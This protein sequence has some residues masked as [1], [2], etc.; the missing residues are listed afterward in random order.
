GYNICIGDG[1]IIN[2]NATILDDAKVTI[3]CGSLLATDVKIY[4]L[5][6]ASNPD[7]R[8]QDN[9]ANSEYR[10]PV[11]IG[12]NCWIGGGAIILP[13]VTIGNDVTVAA[14]AVVNKDVESRCLVAGVP[15]RVVKWFPKAE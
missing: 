2:R 1:S 10:Y 14:G 13:G 3:G 11:T 4:T 9:Q 7:E 5:T 6:H 12:N 8:L 15:A